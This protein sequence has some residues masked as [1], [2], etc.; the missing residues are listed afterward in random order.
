MRTPGLRAYVFT[1]L[2]LLGLL[3]VNTLIAFLNLGIFN[4]VIAIGI[5][6]IMAFLVAGILMHGFFEAKLIPLIIATG[7][8]WFLFM[9]S[10][11]AGDY[12]TRGWVPFHSR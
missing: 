10:N 2:G 12:A 3:L 4:T 1:Y 5:A 6:V 8:I 7:I 9:L 11:V